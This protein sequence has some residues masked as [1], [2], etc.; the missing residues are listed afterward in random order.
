MAV[1]NSYLGTAIT[2]DADGVAIEVEQGGTYG[3]IA[4]GTSVGTGTLKIQ[5][6]DNA[7]N[8]VDTTLNAVAINTYSTVVLGAK[9]VRYS[10]ADATSP[11][12]DAIV[13]ARAS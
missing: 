12:I 13:I 4:R 11:D 10:L 1:F 8:W 9:Y 2:A 7:T 6:S 5:V 3:V